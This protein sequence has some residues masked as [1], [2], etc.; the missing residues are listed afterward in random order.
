MSHSHTRMPARPRYHRRLPAAVLAIAAESILF[1][2][3]LSIPLAVVKAQSPS[4]VVTAHTMPAAMGADPLGLP[5]TRAGSGT[6]WLP[7]SAPMYGVMRNAGAWMLMMHGT[8][9][10]QQIVQGGP[11]GAS[12]FGSVN[13]GMIN[14]MRTVGGGRLQLRGM[15]SVDAFTVGGRGYPLLLQTGESYRNEALHDRQHPHD[16]FMELAAVYEH[17]LTKSVGLQLYAAPS[18]EPALGPVAFPHR[19]SAAAD[20]F[21]TIGHHWQDATHVSFGVVTAGVYSSRLK[22]E[23]S[24]F[25]GR[26]PDGVRTNID[27]QGARLDSYAW[28]VTLNPSPELSLSTSIGRLTDAEKAHPG[29]AVQREVTSLL[30]SRSRADGG[31]RSVAIILGSNGVDDEASSYG[32]SVEAMAELRGGLQLTA[33]AEAVEKS[34]E[35]LVLTPRDETR[36]QVGQLS[37]GALRERSV[38]GAGRVG[39]GARGTVNVVPAPLRAAYGS[40]F[41]LG[42]AVY[43]RWRTGR[44][45]MN[46]MDGMAGMDHMNHKP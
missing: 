45:V 8:V 25:N 1:S 40:R 27:W 32:V 46:A 20:P 4:P 14:A 12:Q 21:A 33:R 6:A 26:E 35:E 28:R 31:S 44:M 34:G 3:L 10:V 30:W 18:G 42:A 11:R 5:M 13:W 9:F 22:V 24:V 38:R 43:L 15:A 16:M 37:L 39:L 36:Y 29:A 2:I 19:P 41:P 17:A 7:D 23:A